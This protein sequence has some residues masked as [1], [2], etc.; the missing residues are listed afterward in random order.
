MSYAERTRMPP[1][2]LTEPDQARLLK[3][4]GEHKDGF[5]L[6]RGLVLPVRLE[7]QLPVACLR[8]NRAS[9]DLKAPLLEGTGHLRNLFFT[10]CGAL[11]GA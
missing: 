4:T 6:F 5:R 11:L 10:A 9:E 1:R 3:T 2:T 8:W 7:H